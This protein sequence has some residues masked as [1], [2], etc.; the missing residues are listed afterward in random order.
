MIFNMNELTRNLKKI[1]VPKAALIAYQE[2]NKEWHENGSYYLELH[3][4]DG[5]GRMRA[6]I[7]VTYEFLNSLLESFSTEIAEM[8][9]GRI[10]ENMIWCDTRKGNEK[11]VW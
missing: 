1:M 5:N 4:I 10:P 8:P 11:Y 2:E 3:P 9:H 6:A 7:P